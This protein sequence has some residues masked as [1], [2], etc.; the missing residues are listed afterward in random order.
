MT[1]RLHRLIHGWSASLVQILLGLTQQLLLI[2]AFLHFWT[3]DVLAA[4]LAIY[5]ASSLLVVA[6]A[7]LQARALNRFLA[8]KSSVDCDGR[9]SSYFADM[10]QIYVRVVLASGAFLFLSIEFF[11]PSPVLG[12]QATPNF[13][14][15]RCS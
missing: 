8:F 3:V 9:T 15:A 12:F 4:W 2:P 13:D 11:P 14:A 1:G 5:S 10:L 7:G 6:D